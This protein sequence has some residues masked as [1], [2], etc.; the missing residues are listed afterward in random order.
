MRGLSYHVILTASGSI[1]DFLAI[2]KINIKIIPLG[3]Q[4]EIVSYGSLRNDRVLSG[5]NICFGGICKI[6][7][8][9]VN[10]FLE[11]GYCGQREWARTR[12]RYGTSF[13]G[14]NNPYNRL[15][16]ILPNFSWSSP[17]LVVSVFFFQQ[18]FFFL[19]WFCVVGLKHRLN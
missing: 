1:L 4:R 14:I 2:F 16:S 11:V 7:V 15:K 17:I 13:L 9:S 3:R 10:F 6:R 5:L 8:I 18:V 19:T 12:S